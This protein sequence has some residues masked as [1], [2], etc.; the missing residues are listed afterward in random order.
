MRS[1]PGAS[2]SLLEE[3]RC[4]PCPAPF[5]NLSPSGDDSHGQDID[6]DI[7]IDIDKRHIVAH[8]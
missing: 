5:S 2:L 6:I 1:P 3:V 4:R 7:D 8:L